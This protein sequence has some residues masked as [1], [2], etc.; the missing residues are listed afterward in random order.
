VLVGSAFG[1]S[2]APNTIAIAMM[3]NSTTMAIT[4]SF[5]TA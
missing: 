2:S 1:P 4:E 5:A 3:T